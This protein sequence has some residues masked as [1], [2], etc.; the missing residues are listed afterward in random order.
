MRSMTFLAA[1]RDY[2]GL[3]PGQNLTGFRDEMVKLTETDRADLSAMFPSVGIQIVSA[4]QTAQ[5]A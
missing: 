3:Q 5:A 4:S 2:F 1:C